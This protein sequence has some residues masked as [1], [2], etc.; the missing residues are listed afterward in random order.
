MLLKNSKNVEELIDAIAKCTGDVILRSVDGTEEFNMKS[1]L[2]QY[3][4]IGRL[5]EERGEY[6]EIFCTNKNDEQYLL[7]FFHE[8]IKDSE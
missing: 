3:I 5:C 6:Y 4:A 7:K 1:A 2:S 8:M